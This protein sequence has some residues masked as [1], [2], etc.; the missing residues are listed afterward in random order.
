MRITRLEN[1][2]SLAEKALR[3][4]EYWNHSSMGLVKSCISLT[5]WHSVGVNLSDIDVR[6]N[7]HMYIII[8]DIVRT[9]PL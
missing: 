4:Y 7:R 9:E 2:R 5:D 6:D 1:G 3:C 8:Q